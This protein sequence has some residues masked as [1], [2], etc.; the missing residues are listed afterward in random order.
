MSQLPY[1]EI[2]AV[3]AISLSDG[4]DASGNWSYALDNATAQS[5]NGGEVI[6]E[7]LA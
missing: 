2:I 3:D 6:T 7:L 5:L 4:D 1:H